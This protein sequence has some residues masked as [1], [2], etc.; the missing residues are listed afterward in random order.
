MFAYPKCYTIDVDK[1]SE[2]QKCDI[3]QYLDFLNYSFKVQSNV[4]N[5]CHH[6]LMMSMNLS[7]V[8]I[9]NN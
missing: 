3:F 2:S 7:V 6:L 8:D 9:L 5:R 4:C 1:T